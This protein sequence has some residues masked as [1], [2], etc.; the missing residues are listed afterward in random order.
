MEKTVIEKGF[1]S[2]LIYKGMNFHVQSEDWGLENPYLVSRIYQNGAVIKSIKTPYTEVVGSGPMS[3]QR[4][5][6]LAVRPVIRLALRDQHQK[7]LDLLL[8][9]QL[10]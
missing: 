3:R 10:F 2:D 9:G 1:N 7:I 4:L 8:S 6:S 5:D